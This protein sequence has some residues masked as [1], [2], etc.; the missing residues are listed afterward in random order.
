MVVYFG[1]LLPFSGV[2][3]NLVACSLLFFSLVWLNRHKPVAVAKPFIFLGDIS[4]S[5]FL[6]H[7]LVIV[8]LGRLLRLVGLES[9]TSGF[10]YFILSILVILVVSYI[11]YRLVEQRLH[12]WLSAKLL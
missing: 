4:Y 11:S 5:L 2:W 10:A 8:F 9:W 1:A 3:N 7:P 6:V 12:R